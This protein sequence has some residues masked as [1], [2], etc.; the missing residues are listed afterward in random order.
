MR[1]SKSNFSFLISFVLLLSGVSVQAQHDLQDFQVHFGKTPQGWLT[2]R[3]WHD[4]GIWNYYVVNPTNFRTSWY[5]GDVQPL[6]PLRFQ[7]ATAGTPY[8]VALATERM[9]D[10]SLQDAGLQRTNISTDSTKRGFSLTVDLCPSR[11]PLDRQFF[12]DLIAAFDKEELPVP[13][14]ISL[15]GIWMKEHPADLM[16]LRQQNARRQLAITWVNHTYHHRFNPKAPLSQNFILMPGTSLIQEILMQEQ[17][18]LAVPLR[19]SVLFRFPGLVSDKAV[20][21]SVLALGLL[22]IGSDAWLAKGQKPINGSLVLVHA[23]GN[24]PQGI[25][26]FFALIRQKSAAI[27]KRAYMVYAVEDGLGR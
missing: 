1:P 26:D 25:A 19:P 8:G 3:R 13:V 20:F 4:E 2:L 21:D 18:M 16:W 17:A 9:R 7:L 14:S 10:R 22:P 23:N 6:S 27:R 5:T 24:E 12:T 11:K 15:T